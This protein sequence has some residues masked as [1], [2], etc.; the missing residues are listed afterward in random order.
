MNKKIGIVF[1][2][3]LLLVTSVV[4][5]VEV[6]TITVDPLGGEETLTFNLNNGQKFSGSLSVSGGIADSII[7]SVQAPNGTKIIELTS[8]SEGTEFDFIADKDGA[9]TLVFEN[10]LALNSKTVSLSYDIETLT[11]A[12]LDGTQILI[13]AFLVIVVIVVG[14]VVIFKKAKQQTS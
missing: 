14:I 11:I 6:E 1:L 3:V 9:Y 5:A 10:P 7:F 12:G 13:V 2:S 8:V 4:Y